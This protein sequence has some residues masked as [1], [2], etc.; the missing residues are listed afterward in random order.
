MR[1]RN[2][3][4]ADFC[5]FNKLVEF[6]RTKELVK[7]N[8]VLKVLQRE[9]T[10]ETFK[11]FAPVKFYT[12]GDLYEYAYALETSLNKFKSTSTTKME[13]KVNCSN[14]ESN[15]FHRTGTIVIAVI[16]G[17][18][19]N[20]VFS[21]EQFSYLVALFLRCT[22]NNIYLT[23][24]NALRIIKGFRNQ[25]VLFGVKYLSVVMVTSDTLS[26]RTFETG[27]AS[28]AFRDLCIKGVVKLVPVGSNY[29]LTALYKHLYKFTHANNITNSILKRSAEF[30][31]DAI[32]KTFVTIDKDKSLEKKELVFLDSKDTDPNSVDPFTWVMA[33]KHKPVVVTKLVQEKEEVKPSHK[34]VVEDPTAVVWTN[35]EP[36]EVLGTLLE[37]KDKVTTTQGNDTSYSTVPKVDVV[38]GSV[39]Y[40]GVNYL[41][42]RRYVDNLHT[43][44]LSGTPMGEVLAVNAED[45]GDGHN[46]MFIQDN[47]NPDVVVSAFNHTFDVMTKLGEKDLEEAKLVNFKDTYIITFE[48]STDLDKKDIM[49]GRSYQVP[50]Y[51]ILAVEDIDFE[52]IKT[53]YLLKGKP[54]NVGGKEHTITE[55]HR[56]KDTGSIFLVLSKEGVKC[57]ELSE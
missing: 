51:L 25:A 1:N 45:R 29:T 17:G 8:P 44:Y 23:P 35:V 12:N 31:A 32:G 27:Q 5:N 4:S 16:S 50:C 36:I 54:F 14:C 57:P 47:V 37:S 24:E 7:D 33:P 34:E 46:V 15:C 22:Y 56:D 40:K 52:Y 53:T 3:V 26:C 20:W 2:E 13:F 49:E 28:D 19:K 42:A 30:F 10:K 55:V 11:G 38:K 18:R 39:G 21:V 6:E 41:V 48:D 9:Y 43:C